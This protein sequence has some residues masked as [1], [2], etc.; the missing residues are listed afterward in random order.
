MNC[1]MRTDPYRLRTTIA[2]EPGE[3]DGFSMVKEVRVS[4]MPLSVSPD[5]AAIASVLCFSNSI[6]GSFAMDRGCSPQVG[7]AI[8]RWFDPADMHVMNIDFEPVARIEG[9]VVVKVIAEGANDRLPDEDETSG[10]ESVLHIAK[11]GTG[12]SATAQRLDLASN[13]WLLTASNG[14]LLERM[15]PAVGVAV[16]FAEDLLA[17]TISVPGVSAEQMEP[18][19]SRLEALLDATGLRLRSVN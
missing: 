4:G 19:W 10:D 11:E 5:R 3:Y 17:G 12:C 9:N 2:A 18:L 16:L 15:V 6:S 7:N 14:T 13:A 1:S 8:R